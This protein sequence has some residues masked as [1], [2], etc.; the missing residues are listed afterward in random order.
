MMKTPTCIPRVL[1]YQLQK[2]QGH[3][4]TGAWISTKR[5]PRPGQH[6]QAQKSICIFSIVSI[7]RYLLPCSK[8]HLHC[9][10]AIW[11][12]TRWLSTQQHTPLL[13][14]ATSTETCISTVSQVLHIFLSH[15]LRLHVKEQFKL[16]RKSVRISIKR[17]SL[18]RCVSSWCNANNLNCSATSDFH[19]KVLFGEMALNA[20]A[21]ALLCMYS[22]EQTHLQEQFQ[23]LPQSEFPSKDS[24]CR[25]LVRCISS[26]QCKQF[27]W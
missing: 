18:A 20:E 23:W 24:L 27:K 4:A 2:C 26:L 6:T 22:S 14:W 13:S 15:I 25:D 7:K 16:W 10:V 21:L 11:I 9:I 5:F 8:L 12:S 17:F 1:Y 19:Q 3:W